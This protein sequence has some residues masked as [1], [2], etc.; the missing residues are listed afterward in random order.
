MPECTHPSISLSGAP[1]E[2]MTGAERRVKPIQM[3][4][5][6]CHPRTSLS[7]TSLARATMQA[8]GYRLCHT[9]QHYRK[10]VAPTVSQ[11]KQCRITITP[12]SN[13][14]FRQHHIS[15]TLLVHHI[16]HSPSRLLSLSTTIP[17]GKAVDGG[18]HLAW[19]RMG[20][21]VGRV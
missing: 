21:L 9:I 11:I 15:H 12:T 16:T 14:A 10:T 2:Y 4:L 17:H 20:Y 19:R 18:N 13:Q 7:F 3:S 1:P 5:L 8:R 6:P